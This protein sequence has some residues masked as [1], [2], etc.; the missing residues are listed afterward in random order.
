MIMGLFSRKK[1]ADERGAVVTQSASDFWQVLGLDGMASSAGENVTYESALGVPAVW[2]AVNF[3]SGTLA[4]LPLHVYRKTEDGREKVEGPIAAILHDAVNDETSSFEWRKWF[5]EQA[6]TGGRGLSFIERN[7]A[8]R[9]KN[10]W[11]MDPAFAT[12]KRKGGRKVYEYREPGA[13]LRVYAAPDVID[14]PFML[15]ADGISHRSPVMANKDAIGLAQAVTKHG[16]KFFS[17]GGVPPFAI[18]GQ[19]QS[20]AAMQRASDDLQ[21][22]VRKAARENRLALTLPAGLEIKQIGLDAEQ[23]QLIETQRFCVEQIARIYSLPPT[24]LQDLTHGTFSN[25]EQQDLHFVKHTIKRWV[26]QFE[27]E[28]NLKLFG[29]ANSA[30]YAEMN[31]DGLLR[32]DFKTRMAGWAEGILTGQVKPNEARRAENRPD[33]DGGDQLYLQGAMVPIK[34]A[35]NFQGGQDDGE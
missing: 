4:G 14:V 18:M 28:L 10:I 30:T 25:T 35:G 17:Q 13:P 1:P 8:G 34:Q 7:K 2:A 16:G 27:Q 15:K 23:M 19:F 3:I 32:G 21:A 11:A 5:F 22:S 6:L 12:V 31:V 29:R 24:F 26:E 20:G 9:V 33:A